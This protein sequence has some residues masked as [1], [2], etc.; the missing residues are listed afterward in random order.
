MSQLLQRLVDGRSLSALDAERLAAL[1]TSESQANLSS[2]EAAL[3]WLAK[4]YGLEFT[5]LESTRD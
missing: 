2:E 3:Q 5:S 1:P 4:E